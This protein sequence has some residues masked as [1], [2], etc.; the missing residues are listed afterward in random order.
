MKYI[1]IITC[2]FFIL[3][4]IERVNCQNVRFL[5]IGKPGGEIDK[6]Y[7]SKGF[8][9]MF[10]TD[11]AN[12]FEEKFPCA[13]ISDPVSVEY[14]IEELRLQSTPEFGGRNVL[15][16]IKNIST[17]IL[18]GYKVS[19]SIFAI[20]DEMA[21]ADVKCEDKKGNV[22]LE[23]SLEMNIMDFIDQH[24]SS[25]ICQLFIKK[26]SKYEICPFKGE[27][28][29]KTVST[30][31]DNQTEE[32][33]VYC[34]GIDGKYRKT[35]TI[36]NYSE[37]DWT[38]QK[39]DKNASTGNVKLTISEVFKIE[40]QNPC[41]KCS[42]QKQ[43]RRT[44][45]EK[46]TTK[47]DIQGLSKESE[48]KEIKVDDARCYLTFLDDGTYTL[49][50][51]ASSKPGVKIT[52]KEISAQGSCNNINQKPKT[53]TNKVDEGLNEIFGPFTGTGLDKMLSHKD[54]IKRTTPSG[55]EETITYEFNLTRE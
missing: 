14:C 50:V 51:T 39:I 2:L 16:I 33:A 52:T 43:A 35:T 28:T 4:S 55:E 32:Y 20:S 19:Y 7:L 53:I 30:K 22:L 40:E 13:S 17:A 10:L 6:H 45:F 36:D 46:I 24:T 34:N 47:A 49:R 12:A 5:F 54:I 3:L 23:F 11:A 38:I 1:K 42:P 29:V 31:K 18:N 27:I 48:S 41:F 37:N 8:N 25:E 15:P 9:D 44:Y 26:L 21:H